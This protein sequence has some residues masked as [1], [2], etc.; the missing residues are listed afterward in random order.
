M[1][2]DQARGIVK[3]HGHCINIQIGRIGGQNGRCRHH[4]LQR[5]QDLGLDLHALKNRLNRKLRP[6][7]LR[8][9][10]AQGQSGAQFGG[11][12]FTDH[13][14]FQTAR[15]QSVDIGLRARD[16]ITAGFQ[17]RCAIARA[18]QRVSDA[19]A[20]CAAAGHDDPFERFRLYPAERWRGLGGPFGKKDMPQRPGLIRAAQ[21]DKGRAFPREPL[22]HGKR[23]RGL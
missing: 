17:N 7:C 9:I 22:L 20:H 13:P 8:D 19:R 11:P 4:V 15:N 14:P 16:S 10:V 6:P 21:F 5:A 1:Q 12:C 3:R 2:P 18:Q 23:F